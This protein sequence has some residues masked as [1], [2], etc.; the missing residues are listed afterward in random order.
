MWNIEYQQEFICAGLPDCCNSVAEHWCLKPGSL[1]DCLPPRIWEA[2]NKTGVT[3]SRAS[4]TQGRRYP[5]TIQLVITSLCLASL[6]AW[7]VDFSC[8]QNDNLYIGSL[9]TQR[10]HT[11]I[12]Y[13]SRRQ[14]WWQLYS[15]PFTLRETTFC[16]NTTTIRTWLA[17]FLLVYF[18]KLHWMQTLTLALQKWSHTSWSIYKTRNLL[19]NNFCTCTTYLSSVSDVW[20]LCLLPVGHPQL[21]PV[22]VSLALLLLFLFH[23]QEV[24]LQT[25]RAEQH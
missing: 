10:I 21:L 17:F 25:G 5:N 16:L 9:F 4:F 1:S 6:K 23:S 3:R 11:C 13:T 15:E 12:C 24:G 22:D 2:G 8:L 14:R 7:E 20:L 19:S 18:T